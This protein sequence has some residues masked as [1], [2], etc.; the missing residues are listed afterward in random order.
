MQ[1]R[2]VLSLIQTQ[3][4]VGIQTQIEVGIQTHGCNGARSLVLNSPPAPPPY[5]YIF[6]MHRNGARSL[7]LNPFLF[8]MF[9]YYVLQWRQSLALTPYFCF[10][11]FNYVMYR[12][13]ARSLALN[14]FFCVCVCGFCLN[15]VLQ[16]CKYCQVLNPFFHIYIHIYIYI[17]TH[18][19]I[20]IYTHTHIYI[21]ILQ[22]LPGPKPFFSLL[23]YFVW[24]LCIALSPGPMPK[25]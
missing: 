23:L 2:Q 11:F 25:F 3:I 15:D 6:T 5:I 4:E 17:Y 24:L 20:Y 19:Y 10:C 1:W 12:I 16:Y 22:I 13:V 18:I 21:S 9:F 14:H 8:R 7:A